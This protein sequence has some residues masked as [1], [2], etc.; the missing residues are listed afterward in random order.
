MNLQTLLQLVRH[1]EKKV[2]LNAVYALGMVDEIRAL[3]TLRKHLATETDPNMQ[4]ALQRVTGYLAHLQ[5]D[6]YDPVRAICAYFN[7]YSDVLALADAR[8]MRMARHATSAPQEVTP[9]HQSDEELASGGIFTSVDIFSTT[10]GEFPAVDELTESLSG[11]ESVS[12]S[13]EKEAR[14]IP[15]VRPTTDDIRIWL[16]R[17]K[18]EENPDTRA[19]IISHIAS[20][21]NPEALLPL[22]HI[23]VADPHP[24]V[25]QAAK[26]FGKQL[27]WRQL[28]W[29]M[30][31]D[32]T[33]DEIRQELAERMHVK[34]PEKK[35]SQTTVVAHESV[36]DILKK[37]EE[38]RA[39]R[40]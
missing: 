27:Y 26:R 35:A 38:R 15:A 28:Y 1:P 39:K 11:L 23:Q 6:G 10:T 17:L 25:R 14:L 33:I 7:V 19:Q 9:Q 22:A 20:I 18:S 29:E 13:R 3:D 30:T 37:A 31:M 12:E 2:R 40:K 8:E 4:K 21:N 34:L 24:K 36:S 32:G 16:Q 5:Q